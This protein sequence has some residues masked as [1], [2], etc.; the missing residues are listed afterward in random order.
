VV[1]D[2]AAR[3]AI[4]EVIGPQGEDLLGPAIAASLA[5]LL[6]QKPSAPPP[7]EIEESIPVE[8]VSP[9]GVHVAPAAIEGAAMAPAPGLLAS[10]AAEALASGV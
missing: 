8:E 3:G 9:S 2:A 6:G 4:S 10:A 5:V 1:R 7:A